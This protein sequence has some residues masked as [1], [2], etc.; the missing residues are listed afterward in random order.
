MNKFRNKYN[1]RSG[2]IKLLYT[3]LPFIGSE[4]QIL[5]INQCRLVKLFNQIIADQVLDSART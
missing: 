3:G 4:W 5:Y 2:S 1:Y